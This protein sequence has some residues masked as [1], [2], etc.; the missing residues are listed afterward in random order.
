M[1]Y[2]YHRGQ[3]LQRGRGVGSIF[4]SLFRWLKPIIPK[5]FSAGKK[6]V[7]QTVADPDV[8]KALTSVKG[9]AVSAGK[10]VINKTLKNIAPDKP[11][12]PKKDPKP[13][14]KAAPKRLAR[15][16]Q[17]AP[18]KKKKPLKKNAATIFDNMIK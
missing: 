9:Q 11:P 15:S 14:V 8:A 2:S 12:P 7:K 13:K 4:T 3:F 5:L 17:V 10:R 1:L 18:V 6:V 16:L